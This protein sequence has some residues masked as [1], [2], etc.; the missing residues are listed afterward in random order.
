MYQLCVVN[1]VW[2]VGIVV[3]RCVGRRVVGQTD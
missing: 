3:V 1:V 2:Y